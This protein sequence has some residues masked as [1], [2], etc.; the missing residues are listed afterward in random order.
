M[1]QR[2]PP[3]DIISF[4]SDVL[5]AELSADAEFFAWSEFGFGCQAVQLAELAYGHPV[6]RRD[7]AESVTAADGVARCAF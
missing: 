1:T 3:W 2:L 4:M 7:A 6:A 5:F